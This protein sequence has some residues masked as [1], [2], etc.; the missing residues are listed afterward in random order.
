VANCFNETNFFGAADS[1]IYQPTGEH[2]ISALAT[3][4]VANWEQSPPNSYFSQ[5]PRFPSHFLEQLCSSN[6]LLPE[7]LHKWPAYVELV[8]TVMRG[9]GL[10]LTKL[11]YIGI[12]ASNVRA[13]DVVCILSDTRIPFI[14]RQR[15][16]RGVAVQDGSLSIPDCYQ[17]QNEDQFEKVISM[18]EGEPLAHCT[19]QLMG[20]A[21]VHGLMNGEAAKRLGWQPGDALTILPIS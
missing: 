6:Y 1:N 12:C 8:T 4:L 21:Y 19:Y 11:G 10:F 13:G 5:D 14:L 20:D 3:T 2:I 9:R 17:F 7:I 15:G 16:G 18:I